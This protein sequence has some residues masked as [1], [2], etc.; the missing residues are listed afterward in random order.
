MRN[1]SFVSYR[2]AAAGL[3]A[4]FAFTSLFTQSAS[5]TPPAFASATGF[6]NS[7]NEI[8]APLEF[9]TGISRSGYLLGDMWGLRPWLSKYG[10]SLAIS[11]TSE[12]LGN[13]TGGVKRGADY[14][15]LTQ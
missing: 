2:Q 5:A 11:E 12:V 9:L 14:D 15:G 6:E 13:A 10:M 7:T 1:T 3:L 4:G 8:I